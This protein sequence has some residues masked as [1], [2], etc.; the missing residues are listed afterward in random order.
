MSERGRRAVQG[1]AVNVS[2]FMLALVFLF[3]GFV[4]ANDPM[5]TV[6]KLREYAVAFGFPQIPFF[7][8][9]IGSVGL[10][11]TEFSLGLYL[12]FGMSRVQTSRIA[13][14]FMAVM[15]LLT[16][17]I[18]AFDPV[19]DC[20]CFG[21][22]IVLSNGAT[23]LKNVVLLSAALVNMRYCRLHLKIVGDNTQW[24][25][26]MYGSVYIL[27]YSVYCIYA[28][29][30]LDYRPYKI[31]T[32]LR[33]QAEG[34]GM[35]RYDIKI[36]YERDGQTLELTPEDDDPDSAWHYVETRRTPLTDVP[37]RKAANFYVT[38]SQDGEDVTDEILYA[39]GYTFLLVIPD[40]L[41]ADEGC[42][43]LVNETYE[44]AREQGYGF[45]CLTGSSS[46]E[47]Q[48]YWSDHTGAEY[49]YYLADESE[50][51]TIVRAAP[52]LVLLKD[53]IVINKWSNYTLPDEYV[54]TDRLE[55]IEIGRLQEKETRDKV[56]SILMYFFL[57]LLAFVLT[58]RI[59]S[60]FALY[61]H[62]KRKSRMMLKETTASH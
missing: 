3:S 45:Y 26:T 43:D 48:A 2:R 22:V 18:Y 33:A 20:G 29:P 49:N 17:Y 13:V 31:G 59:G 46:P 16:A 11:L 61:R 15:T 4:K 9:V 52:G 5:G 53:G 57:P 47:A 30:V 28:L 25:V 58:D 1:I 55:N 35:Q 54:L 14:G 39:D 24:L 38:E 36:I 7:P 27:L 10:A 51:K 19:S 8:L 40:L 34:S 50:L 56:L 60:G 42:V 21:D 6:F 23:L 62:W 12:L 37:A 44:Y 32:D 41:H